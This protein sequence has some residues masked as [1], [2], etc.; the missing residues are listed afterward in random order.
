MKK[1][2]W[3]GETWQSEIK[4]NTKRILRGTEWMVYK[5]KRKKSRFQSKEKGTLIVNI[6]EDDEENT[7]NRQVKFKEIKVLFY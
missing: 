2:K 5:S 6:M 4:L 7:K 3:N 1:Q